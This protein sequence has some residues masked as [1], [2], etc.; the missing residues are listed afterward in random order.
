M[1]WCPYPQSK[2]SFLYVDGSEVRR[3][4]SYLIPDIQRQAELVADR[5][6]EQAALPWVPVDF[7]TNEER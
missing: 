5:W 3:F 2:G 4:Q 7:F 6:M 1:N